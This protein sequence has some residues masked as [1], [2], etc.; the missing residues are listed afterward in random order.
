MP[1]VDHTVILDFTKDAINVSVDGEVVAQLKAHAKGIELK[2]ALKTYFGDDAKLLTG[3]GSG[4]GCSELIEQ[5]ETE[6]I[7]QTGTGDFEP[8]H[9]DEA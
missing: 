1:T 4:L 2:K 8:H 6:L 9:D 3:F 7:V 5:V